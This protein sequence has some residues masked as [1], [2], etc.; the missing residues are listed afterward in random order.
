MGTGQRI[1]FFTGRESVRP[2]APLGHKG[3]IPPVKGKWPEGPKGVGTLSAKLTEGIRTQQIS[4]H[5]EIS[6]AP[7]PK[8][9]AASGFAVIYQKPACGMRC[10]SVQAKGIPLLRHVWRFDREKTEKKGQNR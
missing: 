5:S 2:K 9:E 6:T 7:T 10:G 8:Q 3:L 1:L 4:K